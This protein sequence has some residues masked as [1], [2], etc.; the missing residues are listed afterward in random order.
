MVKS[1]AAPSLSPNSWGLNCGLRKAI[2]KAAK[3]NTHLSH[4]VILTGKENWLTVIGDGGS[5]LHLWP[6]PAS[7]TEGSVS[8]QVEPQSKQY[9]RG[10]WNIMLCNSVTCC[11]YT[12]APMHWNN[13]QMIA[14]INKPFC[15]TLLKYCV[16]SYAYYYCHCWQIRWQPSNILSF[17][18]FQNR[19]VTI[20]QSGSIC[21]FHDQLCNI[22]DATWKYPIQIIIFKIYAFI[23]KFIWHV[24]VTICIPE[25]LVPQHS[26]KASGVAPDI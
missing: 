12:Y 15:L 23:L 7:Y 5:P 6:V 8:H 20:H 16:M 3:A 19:S 22:I 11:T 9:T 24:C 25:H 1:K 26:N 21:W 2:I 18:P 14:L 13:C 10:K 4:H 17:D